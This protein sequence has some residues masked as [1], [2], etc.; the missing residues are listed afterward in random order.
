MKIARVFPR[1]TTA[2]PTDD[3]VFCG[4]PPGIPPEVDEV[5]ISV[6]WSYDVDKAEGLAKDWA[7]IAPVKIGGPA[8][9]TLGVE[10]EPGMYVKRGYVITSRGCPNNCW[11]CSVPKREGSLRELSI[12]DGWNVLDDNLL[13]C[14]ESHIRDVFKMLKN[15]SERAEFTGGLEAA[16]LIDW[17]VNL[18]WDLRPSQMFF[19]YDA[20]NDLEHLIRAGKMLMRADFTRRH[21]RC[22]VLIGFPN[23]TFEKAEERLLDSWNAGFMPMAMLWRDKTGETTEEWRKFQRIWARPAIVRSLVKKLHV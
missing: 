8:W 23:D 7:A 14:S 21:L 6:T 20:P 3:L 19:A 10:F 13:A 1:E 18:L 2:T 9:G 12:K 22:F 15:Q 16:R 5:H 11:F 17:H 4:P